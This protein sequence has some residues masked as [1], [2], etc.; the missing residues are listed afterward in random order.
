MR[1]LVQSVSSTPVEARSTGG[2]APIAESGSDAMSVACTSPEGRSTGS[3]REVAGSASTEGRRPTRIL[4][5]TVSSLEDR[6]T[7]IV[8]GTALNRGTVVQYVL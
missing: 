4:E 3:M 5:V 8:C 1:V 7:T 2:W 6:S